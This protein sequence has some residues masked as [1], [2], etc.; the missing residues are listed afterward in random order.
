MGHLFLK[1]WVVQH[2]IQRTKIKFGSS[3]LQ[4]SYIAKGTRG[5]I[6]DSHDF[7]RTCWTSF[8][9]LLST[10]AS[11]SIPVVFCFMLFRVC[12]IEPKLVYNINKFQVW[13]TI[14]QHP[15]ILQSDHHQKS[16]YHPSPFSWSL[17]PFRSPPI[18]FPNSGNH[19]SVLCIYKFIFVLFI[20]LYFLDS[21]YEWN[22]TVFVFRH[23][24]YFT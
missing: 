8:Q 22:H 15:Y 7:Y 4:G 20:H 18:P 10:K 12:F 16:S 23:L 13:N 5:L 6:S 19:Q 24:T 17:H 21:I 2:Y 1:V 9:R 11:V 14:I 3:V